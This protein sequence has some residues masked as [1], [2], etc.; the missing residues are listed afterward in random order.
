MQ[1]THAEAHKLIQFN[2]DR[3]LN[4][5]NQKMLFAHLQECASCRAYADGMLNVDN[6]LRLLINKQ[7]QFHPLPLSIGSIRSKKNPHPLF[8]LRT[9][10]VSIFLVVF[11]FFIWELTT[12][13]DSSGQTASNILP[14]P[15][16]SIQIST[17]SIE[18]PKC[19][20]SLHKVDRLDTLETLAYQYSVSKEDI[21][22]FNNMSSDVIYESMEIKIPQCDAT[23]TATANLP[24]MIL[25]PILELS[26]DT[27]G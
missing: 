6:T 15:T 21:M 25:A 26:T 9:A 27:P 3:A 16:P 17:A 14:V 8:Q 24:T 18:A 2:L 11:S 7:W 23:P 22:I 5:E 19:K 10:L 12:M 20:W 1:I 13:Y 4:L